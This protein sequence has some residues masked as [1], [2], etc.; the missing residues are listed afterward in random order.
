MEMVKSRRM[1]LVYCPGPTCIYK[2]WQYHSLIV[3]QFSIKSDSISF[4][5]ICAKSAKCYTGF[6]SSGC[7]FIINVHCSG[8][9]ASQIGEFINNLQ[10]LSIHCDSWF[11]VRLS[12]C[13]LVYYLRLFCADCDVKLSHAFD[14]DPRPLEVFVSDLAF[15]ARSSA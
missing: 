8:E 3:V 2:G 13:W 4:P 9:S 15:S 12:R 1:T 5:D 7:N 6:C 11:A 14:I 10:F